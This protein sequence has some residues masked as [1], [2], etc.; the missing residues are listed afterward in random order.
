MT[1]LENHL[2]EKG[3]HWALRSA[4]ANE[5]ARL[6]EHIRILGRAADSCTLNALGEVCDTCRCG[7]AKAA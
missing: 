5:I 4:A 7:K 6:R 2:R 3:P 1:D